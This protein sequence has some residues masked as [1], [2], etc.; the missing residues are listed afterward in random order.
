M[1]FSD[2][3]AS[4]T[5]MLRVLKP[6]ARMAFAVWSN[7]QSNPFFYIL[8]EVLS[9]FIESPPE[10]P[11]APGAFRFAEPTKLA[12]FLNQAG[13]VDVNEQVFDFKIEA[14]LSIDEFWTVRREMSDSLRD[15]LAR[16]PDEQL[17]LAAAEVKEAARRFVAGDRISF[18]AQT[19]I[20]AGNKPR[21]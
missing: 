18:P 15:K 7:R 16:L 20:V 5:Q 13:A 3:E 11:D 6:G 14:K 17:A 2:I 9:R 19:L 1:F 8:T 4:L 10:D 21:R 12:R